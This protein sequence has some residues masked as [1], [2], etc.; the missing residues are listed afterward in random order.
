MA[1]NSKTPDFTAFD[2]ASPVGDKSMF[3]TFTRDEAGKINIKATVEIPK[4]PPVDPEAFRKG[5]TAELTHGNMLNANRFAEEIRKVE[6]RKQRQEYERHKHEAMRRGLYQEERPRYFQGAQDMVMHA[7]HD[8]TVHFVGFQSSVGKLIS[9]GWQIHAEQHSE[10]KTYH[11]ITAYTLSHRD[12]RLVSVIRADRFHEADTYRQPLVINHIRAA[13]NYYIESNVEMSLRAM[14]PRMLRE[15]ES[16]RIEEA[17][18]TNCRI[19]LSDLLEFEP[20]TATA[21]T[22]LIVDPD[23]VQSLLDRIVTLQR[24][25]QKE[26]REAARKMRK[27]TAAKIITLSDYQEAV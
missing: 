7:L 3:T 6:E 26:L 22:E 23:Q 17:M 1:N 4:F 8:C 25:K 16:P 9:E 27:N 21:P 10:T 24:P 20:I 14:M 18:R 2:L 15:G 5:L 19:H 11:D 13:D 12:L